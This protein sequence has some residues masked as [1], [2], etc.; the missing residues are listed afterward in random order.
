[1]TDQQISS[2]F[3]ASYFEARRKFLDACAAR[4]L[5]VDSR[6][7]PRAKGPGGED[8]FTDVVRIGPANPQKALLLISG[9]HGVEGYCGSGPQVGLLET[10]AFDALPP[11]IAV[12]M[13]HA[14]NPYGFAHDRRVN[15]DNIDLNRNFLDWDAISEMPASDYNTIS[16]YVLPADWDGPAKQAADAAI[17]DYI[18]TLG[19]P[20][21]QAALSSGQYE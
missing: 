2:Y 1:M 7:N 14:I 19:M 21:F 13:I 15:E 20:A 10:G 8:L 17:D 4:S 12:V 16:D 18:E 9:T 5:S 11:G 3:S 6:L